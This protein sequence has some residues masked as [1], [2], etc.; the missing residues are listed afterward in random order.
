MYLR[1]KEHNPPHIHA[2]RGDSVGMF[3]LSDGMMFEGDLDIQEQRMVK[4]FI[5]RY[6]RELL[7]MWETQQFTY[8]EPVVK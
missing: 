7:D 1:Q 6:G 3:S 4:Q 5:E 2:I 8:L